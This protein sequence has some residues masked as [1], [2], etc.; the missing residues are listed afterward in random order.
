MNAKLSFKSEAGFVARCEMDSHADTCV[1]GPNFVVDEYTGENC[2]VVPYSNDYQPIKGVPIVN[3]STAYTHPETGETVILRFNQVLW[4]GHA[5][6]MSL[7]NPNQIRYNGFTLS[8]DPTDNNR[9]FGISGTDLEI[10]FEITGTT[11]LFVSHSPSQWEL[12]NCRVVELTLDSPWNPQEVFIRGLSTKGTNVEATTM[13]QI[14]AVDV[15]LGTHCSCEKCNSEF[16]VYDD[17]HM[18][19]KMIASVRVATTSRE[20]TLSFVGARDRHS[21][22]DAETVAKRFR[23][24][25]ETARKTLKA[26][27][28]RGV[29]HSMHP[30]NRRYRVDHLNLHRQRLHD[31]FYT[32]TLFSKVKSLSGFTCAQLITNGT[33]T[34]VY[35]MESKSGSQIAQALGEF[36]SD[37]GIPD[38]LTCDFATEQTGPHTEVVKLMRRLHIK[39]RIAEKGRSITQNSR[40]EAEIREVKTKWKARMRSSQVPPRL[41]DYGLVYI[42]EIQSILARGPDFR[43]GIEC[44]TGDNVDI[45]EWLDFDFYER[46]WYWDQ[47]KMD[48]TDEQARIGRWLGIA[49]RVGSDMTYWILTESGR[50]IARSTVQHIT[51]T[52]MATDAMKTRVQMF[53]DRLT[54]RLDMENFVIP[55]PAGAFYLDDD[56]TPRDTALAPADEEY[57]DMIQS[58][59]LEADDT[60]FETFDKYIGAEFFVNDNGESAPARV[61]KR[62]RGNDGNPIG[63]KHLYPLLDTS[64]YD[65]ELGDGTVYRYSA[66]VIAEN[67]FSQCDDEGRRHAVL[68]EITDHR[69]DGSAVHI[70]NGFVTT[71]N[72]H[73]IP[74]TTTKGWELLVQ[75]RDGTSDWISL[76][77]LK[78][79]NP[80]ELA[81][82]AVANRIQE[83]PAFKWWV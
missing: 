55:L 20:Q 43:T 59:T 57:G 28:Q 54:E 33:F 69:S 19:S 64:V 14:H 32:D 3:A 5:M 4:Y 44:L 79:S 1:A 16:D 63:K 31:T 60:E 25:L 21:Q 47:K 66:N 30:L 48:M 13:R 27:T 10:P 61:V 45:S 26:T 42:A 83:E 46:V 6:D 24:G 81:E 2:D 73:R 51:V 68:Q 62:S 9:I 58:G 72:G 11:V 15:K 56:D 67:I 71:R 65:C 36:I 8:D 75:W 76:K 53:D 77:H 37:V 41:W 74:K 35:P 34:R 17:G 12:D 70:S 23:C 50:V 82:Y 40:A 52:D 38:T 22:V 80:I 7:L 49:H 18:I 39:P 78:E 29:R